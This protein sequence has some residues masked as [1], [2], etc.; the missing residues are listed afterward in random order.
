MDRRFLADLMGEGRLNDSE[1]HELIVTLTSEL[2]TR[3]YKLSVYRYRA[4]LI[5]PLPAFDEA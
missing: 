2:V 1:A 4:A 5:H 3:A